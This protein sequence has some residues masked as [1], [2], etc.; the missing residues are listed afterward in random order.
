MPPGAEEAFDPLPALERFAAAGV[1]FVVIGAV[2]GGAHGSAFTTFDLDLAY[3]READNL[4]RIAG[5]LRALDA[6]L[7]GAP[8][9]VPFPLDA[10]T[11]AAGANFTFATSVGSVDLLGDLP[12][13]P[14][15]EQ[16]R[17]AATIIDV[18]GHDVRVASLDHLIAM[19]EAAGRTKDKAMATEYRILSDEIRAPRDG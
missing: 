14:P 3:S 7:R 12:G 1:D 2:A 4:E 10:Q 18:R 9:D 19:K 8:E 6:R 11:L 16:L 17:R 13:S 15:Y 5:V